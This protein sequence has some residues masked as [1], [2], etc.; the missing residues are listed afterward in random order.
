MKT[1][2]PKIN[3]LILLALFTLSA[4]SGYKH[5]YQKSS[6]EVETT[7]CFGACPIYVLTINGNGD[8]QLNNKMFT[9]TT[10]I[11]TNKFDAKEIN[12]LFKEL[13][14][15]DWDNYSDSYET[16]YSDLPGTLVT[17]KH[18]KVIKQISI[19]GGAEAPEELL[20]MI[21]ELKEYTKKEDW[22]GELL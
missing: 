9:P 7:P 10:G 13:E 1:V 16:Y 14:S 8:A 12:N 18:K 5:R 21:K 2:K 11:F 6:I 4:C 3:G 20:N 19:P 17:Y 15:L 22:A